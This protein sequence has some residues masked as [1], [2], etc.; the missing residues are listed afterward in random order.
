MRPTTWRVCSEIKLGLLSYRRRRRR[1][2][3]A[4]S[5]RVQ[6]KNPA[7]IFQRQF[8][9]PSST[10]VRL[11]VLRGTNRRPAYW[12][13]NRNRLPILGNES[14][15]GRKIRSGTIRQVRRRSRYYRCGTWRETHPPLLGSGRVFP[16]I[17]PTK[18]YSTLT[19]EA[20]CRGTDI[21]ATVRRT[22]QII[23]CMDCYGSRKTQGASH[24]SG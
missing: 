10:R 4:C 23:N 19:I 2:T 17:R 22:V 15:N 21:V 8:I 24:G 9:T 18:L 16:G 11:P 3:Y 12:C 14:T 6:P 20:R 1:F 7:F 13:G 5:A